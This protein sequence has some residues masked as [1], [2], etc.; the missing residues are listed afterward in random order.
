MPETKTLHL[1]PAEGRQIRYPD[2]PRQFLPVKGDHVPDSAY[3]RRRLQDRDVIE[4]VAK[5][6]GDK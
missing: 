5:D 1:K 3:W 6:K 2:N 4:I